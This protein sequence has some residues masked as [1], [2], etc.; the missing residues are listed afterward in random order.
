MTIDNRQLTVDSRQSSIYSRAA[1][2][3]ALV[4]SNVP[5]VLSYDQVAMRWANDK[6]PNVVHRDRDKL[7]TLPL[8]H[9][10]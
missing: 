6:Y 4:F 10:L 7:S 9:I 5:K 1:K 8:G 3:P 2:E